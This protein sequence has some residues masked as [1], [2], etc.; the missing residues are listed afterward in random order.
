MLN[1][2]GEMPGRLEIAD[3]FFRRKAFIFISFVLLL[4]AV[5][6]AWQLTSGKYEAQMVLLVRNTRAEVVVTPGQTP[7]AVAPSSLNE[8]Q[9]AT[10]VQLLVSRNSLRQVVERCK[11]QPTGPDAA[12]P[13]A[14]D[15]AVLALERA[16]RVTPLAKASMIVVRYADKDPALAAMVL[17]QLLAV[18]TDQHIRVHKGGG[19]D[20]FERQSEE[21]GARL[22]AAEQRLAKFQSDKKIVLLNEQKNLNLRRLMELESAHRESQLAFREGTQRIASLREMTANLSPRITTQVRTIPNHVLVER[23]NT[24]LVDLDNK[25][26]DLLA[27]F[28][29]DDRLVKQVEQQIADT[30]TSLDRAT[31]ISS[32]EQASDV[33]PLRQSLEADL[34]R[35]RTGQQVLSARLSTLAAQSM[36]Y[37][38][39]IA[40]LERSTAPYND[41]VREVKSLEENYQLYSRKWEESRIADALDR[42]KIANITVVESPEV[43]ASPVP[44]SLMLPIGAILLG[45]ALILIAAVLTG[46]HG[47]ILHTPQSVYLASG[48]QVL[49]TVPEKRVKK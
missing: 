16:I 13:A 12:S 44:R 49:A 11:L 37:R 34:A 29:A 27:K 26:T 47:Q 6:A 25:R 43:P 3:A 5:F 46:L 42:Q 10:E 36:E 4:A 7:S 20:F 18:Y 31:R 17:Q 32:S 2:Y 24:M 23:L 22:R 19:S 41:M 21:Q 28:R 45:L 1:P 38:A 15:R 48:I 14:I 8:G 9:I 33:N 40:K 39:E 30:R 35:T